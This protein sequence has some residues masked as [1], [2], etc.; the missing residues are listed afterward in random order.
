MYFNDKL[1]PNETSLEEDIL[2]EVDKK[3]K[4]KLSNFPIKKDYFEM[5]F[6]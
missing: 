5:I 1:K 4:K 2:N 3:K 6:E